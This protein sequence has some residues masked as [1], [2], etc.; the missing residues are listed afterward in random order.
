M[1]SSEVLGLYRQIL[2][3]SQ[4]FPLKRQ[5]EKLKYNARE[6]MQMRKHEKN[7]SNIK[8]YIEEGKNHLEVLKRISSLDKNVLQSFLDENYKDKE[9][10]ETYQEKEV[11]NSSNK[12]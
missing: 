6:V 11:H 7:S 8:Q 10:D 12:L 1:S 9:S 4:Q 2:R 5:R 3:T